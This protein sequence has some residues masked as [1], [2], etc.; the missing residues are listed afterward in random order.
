MKYCDF[1]TFNRTVDKKTS[2]QYFSKSNVLS[3]IL[4][5]AVMHL[6]CYVL[7]RFAEKRFLGH[8]HNHLTHLYLL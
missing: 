6:A 3:F 2:I 8:V 5:Y 1:L 7:L 4:Q